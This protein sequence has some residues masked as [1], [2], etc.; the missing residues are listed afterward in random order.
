MLITKKRKMKK[1]ILIRHAKSSWQYNINDFER[2]LLDIGIDKSIKVAQKAKAFIENNSL[3]LSSSSKRAS[4]TAKIFLERWNI[5]LT[6]IT[7]LNSLYTFDLNQLEKIVKSS[8]NS[9]NNLIL[10]GHNT[11]I[12]DFVNK[13]GDI[14]IDNVP[15]SGF[16]SIIFE[17]TSW[18]DINKGKTDKVLF[19][20]DI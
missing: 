11:A 1:L 17:A 2:P 3:I 9:Y 13:F 6:K 10:F 4:E 5:N 8:P 15:T 18:E 16:V 19:P 12:T 14:F 7:F 20:R